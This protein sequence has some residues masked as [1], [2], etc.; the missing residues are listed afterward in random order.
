MTQTH[1][2][3][4]LSFFW[5]ERNVNINYCDTPTGHFN[6]YRRSL[7]SSPLARIFSELWEPC[8]GRGKKGEQ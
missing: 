4:E 3:D 2:N 1:A 8:V 7:T 6:Y 5:A